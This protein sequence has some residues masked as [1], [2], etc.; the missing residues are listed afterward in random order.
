MLFL[1]EVRLEQRRAEMQKGILMREAALESMRAEAGAHGPG[2]CLRAENEVEEWR[3]TVAELDANAAPSKEI[4]ELE[5]VQR[6]KRAAVIKEAI[7]TMLCRP[8]CGVSCGAHSGAQ[9]GTA[10]QSIPGQDARR[11]TLVTLVAMASQ[12]RAAGQGSRL[13]RSG[14]RLISLRFR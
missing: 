9:W 11:V 4:L 2:R 1:C 10:W 7:T 14:A 3:K 5:E 8:A 6:Q 13:G 12:G